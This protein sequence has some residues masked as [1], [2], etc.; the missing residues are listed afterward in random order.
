V[1][2]APP[3]TIQVEIYIEPSYCTNCGTCVDLCSMGVFGVD[4]D[5]RI[6]PVHSDICVGC[7]KCREFCPENAIQP[8]WIV[9]A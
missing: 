2:G 3:T 9:R 8:R 4:G 5:S 6:L 1:L 7:F